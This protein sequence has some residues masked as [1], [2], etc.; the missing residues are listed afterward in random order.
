MSAVA[1]GATVACGSGAVVA[2]LL[3]KEQV[4]GSTPVFRSLFLWPGAGVNSEQ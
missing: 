2:R 4:A 1:N 3:A